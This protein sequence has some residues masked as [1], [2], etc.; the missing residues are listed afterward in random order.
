MSDDKQQIAILQPQ[1][2]KV[3]EAWQSEGIDAADQLLKH[4]LGGGRESAPDDEFRAL[5]MQAASTNTD[6]LNDYKAK[7]LL[8]ELI[9]YRGELQQR[10][11]Y[12]PPPFMR[13]CDIDATPPKKILRLAGC[14]GA[15]LVE[16][17]V[18]L[19]SGKGGGG[20][21][22]YMKDLCLAM[23]GGEHECAGLVF[24]EDYPAG[25]VD[26]VFASAEDRPAIIKA[27]CLPMV[28][29][30]KWA[31]IPPTFH[32][33]DLSGRLLYAPPISKYPE[34]PEVTKDF[35]HLWKY[36]EQV[37]A[38]L[39]VI[40]CASAVYAG[41]EN[42]TVEV[43]G[44]I[45]ALV[46]E[47]RRHTCG[48]ILIAHSTKVARNKHRADTFDPGLI[49]GSAAWHDGVR[50]ALV[51]DAME[52]EIKGADAPLLRVMKANY[53]PSHLQ[54][55]LGTWINDDGDITGFQAGAW[56]QSVQKPREP[57][58]AGKRNRGGTKARV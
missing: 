42:R 24:G 40:D 30:R 16:G 51:M 54:S 14:S 12:K 34:P 57:G 29:R 33:V 56:M 20:K 50:G 4:M 11:E 10:L 3:C 28:Q 25:K 8:K 18:L 45:N 39:L 17:E 55:M 46:R 22:L 47:A 35:G 19:F 43:R 6:A 49:S 48:V 32:A 52:D 26:V 9:G 36:V 1:I 58:G 2:I 31:S 44:F 38:R 27:R 41:Q 37:G 21:S 13:V 53:G 23:A 5:I 15:L 7:A